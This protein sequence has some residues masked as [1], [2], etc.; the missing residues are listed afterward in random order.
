MKNE[1]HT[2]ADMIR[3]HEDIATKTAT[4]IVWEMGGVIMV[5][6]RHRCVSLMPTIEA[7]VPKV[8]TKKCLVMEPAIT[9]VIMTPVRL[10]IMIVKV[11]LMDELI[12]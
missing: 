4:R 11:V 1:T 6:V 3:D 5:S 10:M 2:N 9:S 8:A 7:G 12:I